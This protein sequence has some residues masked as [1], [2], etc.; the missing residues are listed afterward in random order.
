MTFDKDKLL[1][2]RE[3][4]NR[5]LRK[6]EV[7]EKD[8]YKQIALSFKNSQ[9][10]IDQIL[11]AIEKD[12]T[13]EQ[14]ALML[15]EMRSEFIGAIKEFRPDLQ[16]LAKAISDL[17]R[18]LSAKRDFND[19]GIIMTLNRIEKIL[20]EKPKKKEDRTD[21]IVKAIKEI[22]VEAK[23]I[24]F[25]ES[26]SINNFP[27]QKVPQ[28]VTNINLNPLGGILHTTNQTLSTT[29][30]AIPS[31]GVLNSRRSLIIYNN[32]STVTIYIGG[33]AVTSSNGLP[34]PPTSYGPIIDASINMIV[35]GLTASSTANIRVMELSSTTQV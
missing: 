15:R 1:N 8:R 34:I 28:P 14:I 11:G 25:P 18:L 32:S 33:S 27:P 12:K 10:S 19:E 5:Y 20:G 22:K 21:E 35:Y 30:A 6:V 9:A 7:D 29:V 17:G 13:A 23:D 2:L 24:E 3:N 16:P 31:Y 4:I 26:I